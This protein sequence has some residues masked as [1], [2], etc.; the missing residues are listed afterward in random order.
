MTKKPELRMIDGGAGQPDA[1]RAMAGDGAGDGHLPGDSAG[2]GHTTSE[3]MLDSGGGGSS[4]ESLDPGGGDTAVGDGPAPEAA[5]PEAAATTAGDANAD[6]PAQAEDPIAELNNRQRKRLKDI[7]ELLGEHGLAWEDIGLK[8]ETEVRDFFGEFENPNDAIAAL[9]A[10]AARAVDIHGS[11]AAE[12][13]KG[14]GPTDEA[15]GKKGSATEGL[16]PH[17]DPS[18]DADRLPR[19][20]G[21]WEGEPGNSDWASDNPEVLRITGDGRVQ[22]VDGEPV[23]A[24]YAEETSIIGNMTG[25]NGPDFRGARDALMDQYPGRWRNRTHLAAWEG[26]G[27]PD[28]WGNALAEQHTWHHEPD[29]ETM[30]LVPTAL[31]ENVPHIGGASPARGGAGP[32]RVPPFGTNP[33]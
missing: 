6:A 30:S 26:G 20:N 8:S 32:E 27:V 29:L 16:E 9:E 33:F 10:R 15:V 25:E 3:P 11:A 12:E 1:P 5:G 13:M 24:P 31:H 4:G 14:P 7:G 21:T 22:F 28:N 17:A 2:S 18:V 19:N 23:L